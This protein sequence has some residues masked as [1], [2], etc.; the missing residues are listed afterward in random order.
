MGGWTSLR[1][2][3][4]RPC[5]PRRFLHLTFLPPIEIAMWGDGEEGDQSL[6]LHRMHC[7]CSIHD[8]TWALQSRGPAKQEKLRLLY[9]AKEELVGGWNSQRL[10]GLVLP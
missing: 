7:C 4:P 10:S 6:P 3:S 2:Q 8:C 5:C 9:E 1:H